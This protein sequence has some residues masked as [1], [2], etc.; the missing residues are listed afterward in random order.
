MD[1]DG[2]E[3]HQ[4]GDVLH[5]G[6]RGDPFAAAVRSARMPMV[7]SDPRRPDNPIVFANDAFLDLTGYGRGE[8]VGRNCRFLQGP[9]TDPAAVRRLKDAIEREEPIQVDLLNHRKDGTPFWNALFVGPVR[10]RAGEVQFYFASQIDV[11]ARVEA[12]AAL[13]RQKELVEAEVRARTAE[14]EAALRQKDRALQEKTILLREVDHRV[15]NNLNLVSALMRLQSARLSDPALKA[16]LASMMERIEAL[17][18]VHRTLHQAAEIGRFG[19]GG[20]LR[21]LLGALLRGAGR[22]DLEVVDRI[23][24][25]EIEAENATALGL[26]ANE[27][28]TNALKHAYPGGRAG[29]LEV[30][31]TRDGDEVVLAVADDG[32]GFDATAMGSGTLG[33]S[34][35]GRLSAQLGGST[36][37]ESSPAGTRSVTR[38]PADRSP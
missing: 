21:S 29:R 25:V 14:L 26:L 18:S 15:K 6:G 38:F 11:T 22:E 31:L 10:G 9:E 7:V 1:D 16:V 5:E 2:G 4:T 35:V 3:W 13:G 36:R 17:S 34:L 12:Q 27:I 28:L 8:V 33:G 19:A 20:F 23:G 37:W 32:P 24:E 30:A